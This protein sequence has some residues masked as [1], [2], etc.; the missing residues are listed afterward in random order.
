MGIESLSVVL[1]IGNMNRLLFLALLAIGTLTQGCGAPQAEFRRYETYAHKVAASSGLDKGFT[2]TQRQDIDETLQALFGTPDVP[3]LPAVE[4]IDLAKIVNLSHLKLAAGPVGSDEQGNPRGLYRE[5]CAHCHG[6][7]GDGV[8]PTA[9]F[10]NPYPRDYRKGQFK[11]KS[12]PVGQKPTHADLK[13]IVLDGVPGT[14]M[15]SFKLLPDLEVEALI[16]YV[17]YLSIRGEVERGLLVATTNLEE[18]IR[19]VSVLPGN[20]GAK[21]KSTQQE[22][23]AAV[24]DVVKNVVEKWDGA[25][26]AVTP[27]PAR[28]SMTKDELAASIKHGRELFYGA[29]ANCVKCHGDS[30]LG[31]GQTTDY[32]EWAKEFINDGK[33]SKVVSTYVSLGL[34]PPRTIRPRNLRQGVFRGG[35]RPIDLYWRMMNGIEGTPMPALATNIRKEGDPA[36]AKKLSAEEVWDIVNYVQSLPYESVSSPNE[37]AREAQI[38]REQQ[39]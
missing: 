28:T 3:T 5:H 36:E 14:A 35:L 32:D 10:L 15:P 1:R 16:E 29:I 6:I 25:P 33:D 23:I 19:L 2:A 27:V 30:A 38:V 24:K 4:G 31:D 9:V 34:L 20:A 17:K 21:E 26:A 37:A 7:S 12:T 8:G 13:K 18:N 11:F 22:Q 39:L